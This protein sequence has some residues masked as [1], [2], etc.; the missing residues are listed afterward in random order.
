MEKEV[1][2]KDIL[3][4]IEVWTWTIILIMSVLVYQIWRF[5]KQH[6]EIFQSDT[7]A[8]DKRWLKEKAEMRRQYHNQ[9]ILS[10]S[11]VFVWMIGMVVICFFAGSVSTTQGWFIVVFAVCAILWVL[12]LV[13]HK[14]KK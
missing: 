5:Q 12:S 10:F 4:Y 8:E 6:P 2:L 9:A 14:P 1:L 7:T 3:P 13:Q 11:V